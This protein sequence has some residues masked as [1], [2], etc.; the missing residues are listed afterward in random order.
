MHMRHC[1]D[2]FVLRIVDDSVDQVGLVKI[3]RVKRLVLCVIHL[4]ISR[5]NHKR[6]CSKT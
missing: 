1:A 2:L 5:F 3:S 4:I 6:I